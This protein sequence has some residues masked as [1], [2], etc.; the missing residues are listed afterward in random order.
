MSQAFALLPSGL[1]LDRSSREPGASA[2][3][4][5]GTLSSHLADATTVQHEANISP[6]EECASRLRTTITNR[7]DC[8]VRGRGSRPAATLSAISA[9]DPGL[10]SRFRYCLM[11]KLGLRNGR[12][13][14]LFMLCH[15][16]A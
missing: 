12:L 1:A 10:P 14:I 8:G 7:A 6:R 9:V 16:G 15:L 13:D 11:M 2:C 3:I 5:Q 4:G